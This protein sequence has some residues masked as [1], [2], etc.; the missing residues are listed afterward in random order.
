[1]Q[2]HPQLRALGVLLLVLLLVQPF[3]ST[4]APAAGT[5]QH[6]THRLLVD[7]SDAAAL[8]MIAQRGGARLADYG[9]F[10]LWRADDGA[11]RAL[12]S[13]PTLALRD[14]FDMIWLRS[15]ALD[16]RAGAPAVSAV[17][18]QARIAGPQLWMVQ[19]VGPIQ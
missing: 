4:I 1:M 5:A 7:S 17:L 13:R 9:G 10:S 19:F 18:R 16:T 14:D 11:A 3:G 2:P 15:G 6:A 8:R 12:G